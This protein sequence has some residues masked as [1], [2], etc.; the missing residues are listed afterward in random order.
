MA[1]YKIEIIRQ[2]KG[3]HPMQSVINWIGDRL[4]K[5]RDTLTGDTLWGKEKLVFRTDGQFWI[6]T[7]K[8]FFKDLTPES[9][10]V[11]IIEILKAKYDR[12]PS[13]AKLLATVR[14]VMEK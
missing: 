12:T 9:A 6:Y 1:E 5:D 14:G 8:D 10:T 3:F 2:E 4:E 13:K 7:S 11:L